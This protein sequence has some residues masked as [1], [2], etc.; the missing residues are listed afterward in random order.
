MHP[1]EQ[2]EGKPHVS[3]QMSPRASRRS[4]STIQGPATTGCPGLTTCC[5]TRQAGRIDGAGAALGASRTKARHHSLSKCVP[6][7]ATTEVARKHT[8]N[9][10]GRKRSQPVGGQCRTSQRAAASLHARKQAQLNPARDCANGCFF[11]GEAPAA[12]ECRALRHASREYAPA[13]FTVPTQCLP[14]KRIPHSGGRLGQADM[15]AD[16]CLQAKFS[17]QLPRHR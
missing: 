12:V 14:T 5:A 9:T 17:A 8:P 2:R 10:L 6:V 3:S 15:H 11:L 4:F 13:Q 16:F 1:L 7:S